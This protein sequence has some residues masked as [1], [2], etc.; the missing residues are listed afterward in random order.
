VT[1]L[2]TRA[3]PSAQPGPLATL[4][5]FRLDLRLAD[6]PAVTTALAR[7][8]AAGGPVIPV[9]VWSPD[10][11]GDAAPGAA[12]RWWLHQSLTAL[13]ASLR[14]LGSQLLIRRGPAARALATLAAETGARCAV[15]TRRYEPQVFARDHDLEAQL[16]TRGIAT[17]IEGGGLLLEP[18]RVR[19]TTG[20]PFQVFTPFWRRVVSILA[21]DPPPPPLPAPRALPAPTR[22]PESIPVDALGLQPRID[23]AAG[24]RATWR[25]GETAARSRLREFLR[26]AVRG[27]G[28]ARD[29]PAHDGTSRLSP[30]LH[31]G[32]ISPRQIWH[33]AR[34]HAAGHPGDEAGVSSYLREIGWREFS[35][36]L[37]FHFPSTVRDPLR[38]A[39]A[40]FPWA[41]APAHLAAWQRGATGYP[42][43]DAGMR[44]LWATGFMHNRVRMV[45][46]SFLTKDLLQPW[47]A[48]ARWFWDTL[49]DADLG[50]NTLGW[51]WVAGSGAD[52]APFF[53]IFHPVT[54][55]QRFDKAGAYVR[56]WVPELARLCDRDI[57]APWQAAPLELAAA[58]VVLG[59]T[60]P[61]P[62]IDH[63]WARLRA[64]EAYG[65]VAS[66]RRVANAAAEA[67]S[68]SRTKAVRQVT[69]PAGR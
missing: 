3:S 50:N 57:Q 65:Q 48:G 69:R 22:W 36:H 66:D 29:L 25:P 16:R 49:V 33:A 40:N 47:Q 61:E 1:I 11:E 26:T 64:L 21:S 55:A 32:E 8:R 28:D 52:A 6:N 9:F 59:K 23:W 2:P 44:E 34:D 42:L 27:Y 41:D 60:Y 18:E 45:A 20:G 67:R 17:V 54:Q 43:V 37:L 7:A 15:W 24:I 58:G 31:H 30:H 53:R 46:A 38:P 56:R 51:Q 63:G 39:F 68:A 35:Q 19:T 10:E 14:E 12:S 13:D 62:I 4:L 5:W